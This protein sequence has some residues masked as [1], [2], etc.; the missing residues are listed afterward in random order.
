MSDVPFDG[1][2]AGELC[3]TR[4]VFERLREGFEHW[5]QADRGGMTLKAGAWIRLIEVAGATRQPTGRTLVLE[6]LETRGDVWSWFLLAPPQWD[7][8]STAPGA[9]GQPYPEPPL[10]VRDLNDED[11][12]AG[13]AAC[14]APRPGPAP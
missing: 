10:V 9:R 11:L 3:A 12:H 8:T 13:G 1:P 2:I 7:Q 6:V 14:A 4:I 5:H